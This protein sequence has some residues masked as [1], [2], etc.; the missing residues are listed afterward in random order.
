M[1]SIWASMIIASTLQIDT[2]CCWCLFPGD[3]VEHAHDNP[4]DEITLGEGDVNASSEP[5][6]IPPEKPVTPKTMDLQVDQEPEVN[7]KEENVAPEEA[8][9]T[10]KKDVKKDKTKC[11]TFFSF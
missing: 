3:Q 2:A 10:K 8:K 5:D 7:G 11:K 9:K 4:L 1:Y 6:E